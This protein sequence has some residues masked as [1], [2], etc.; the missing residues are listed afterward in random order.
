MQHKYNGL[1]G[2]KIVRVAFGLGASVQQVV[3]GR[4]FG[5]GPNLQMTCFAETTS[6]ARKS[7]F[8]QAAHSQRQRLCPAMCKHT[9]S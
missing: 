7:S 1:V 8:W 5:F 4:S 6:D 3:R 2:N 9:G